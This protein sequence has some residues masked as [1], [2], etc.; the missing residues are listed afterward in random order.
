MIAMKLGTTLLGVS[1]IINWYGATG[2]LEDKR[3]SGSPCN[4]SERDDCYLA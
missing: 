4:F 1:R 2:K 3:R